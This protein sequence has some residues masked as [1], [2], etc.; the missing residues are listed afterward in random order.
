[1]EA[2]A[3][4]G[5]ESRTGTYSCG[6]RETLEGKRRREEKVGEAGKGKAD[7][8]ERTDAETA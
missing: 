8:P 5:Q 1:M 2:E 4:V 3:G 6:Q 7:H